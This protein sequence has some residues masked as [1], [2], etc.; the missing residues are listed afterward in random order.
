MGALV[1]LGEDVPIV[2]VFQLM[3][4]VALWEAQPLDISCLM[5]RKH[6]ILNTVQAG[7][8]AWERQRE[9]EREQQ[10]MRDEANERQGE[11]DSEQQVLR[12]EARVKH[13]QLKSVQ[14]EQNEYGDQISK[15]VGLL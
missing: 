11:L 3:N 12:E 14:K 1:D 4:G 7:E 15:S 8:E 6:C 2:E 5:S 13:E 10:L 9:L